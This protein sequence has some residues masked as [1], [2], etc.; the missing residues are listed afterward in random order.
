MKL[1][2]LCRLIFILKPFLAKNELVSELNAAVWL[3]EAN[4]VGVAIELKF[5]MSQ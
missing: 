3:L 5:R 4:R 1:S 2:L